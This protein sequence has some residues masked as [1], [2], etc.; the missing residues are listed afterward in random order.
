MSNFVIIKN[1]SLNSLVWTTV[2][3]CC[4]SATAMWPL[5]AAAQINLSIFVQ[6][7]TFFGRTLSNKQ[8]NYQQTNPRQGWTI[9]N[10]T[11]TKERHQSHL[12]KYLFIGTMLKRTNS[13]ISSW[14]I[15][16]RKRDDQ[17][18][19]EFCAIFTHKQRISNYEI[20]HYYSRGQRT[21]SLLF[22]Q[23]ALLGLGQTHTHTHAHTHTQTGQSLQTHY[24][25]HS[26]SD[27]LLFNFY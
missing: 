6:V 16:R 10:V 2:G 3:R 13:M 5:T 24:T 8:D 17:K 11:S 22:D 23:S 14:M 27:F 19:W 26:F 18:I 1:N 21:Y 12:F 20:L 7:E 25:K 9:F 4:A 15:E